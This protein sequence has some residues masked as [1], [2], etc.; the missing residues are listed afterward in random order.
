MISK[1]E[2]SGHAL[3]AGSSHHLPEVVAPVGHRVVLGDLNLEQL[4][5]RH[6]RRQTGGAL[7]ATSTNSCHKT[8]DVP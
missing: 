3:V 6:E 5:V 8:R 7:A 1:Q 2:D 4:K